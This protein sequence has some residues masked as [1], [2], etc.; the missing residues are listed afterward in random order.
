MIIIPNKPCGEPKKIFYFIGR[1]LLIVSIIYF[2]Q[3]LVS[4]AIFFAVLAN[5]IK[6]LLT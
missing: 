4:E 6:N 2:F 1:T 3:G 5:G